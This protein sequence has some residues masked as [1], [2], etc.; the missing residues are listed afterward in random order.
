MH[1]ITFALLHKKINEDLAISLSLIN[2]FDL[3]EDFSIK[4]CPLLIAFGRMISVSDPSA[5]LDYLYIY[6]IQKLIDD[7][8]LV[9]TDHLMFYLIEY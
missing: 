7:N 5:L 6:C 1:Y 2:L 9:K 4:C 3:L 8:I